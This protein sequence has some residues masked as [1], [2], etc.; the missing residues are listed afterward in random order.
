MVVASTNVQNRE[1]PINVTLS[2]FTAAYDGPPMRQEELANRQR[3]L[4]EE[5]RR[6]AEE[7]RKK[8]QEAQDNAK[9]TE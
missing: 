8:L 5:L 1:N 4:Q 6:K 7:A 9:K 3:E 2:G